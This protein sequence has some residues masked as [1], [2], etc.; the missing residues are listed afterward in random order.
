MKNDGVAVRITHIA[1]GRGDSSYC[2]MIAFPARPPLRNTGLS[3]MA[4]ILPVL[5]ACCCFA[6][7][8]LCW[9]SNDDDTLACG[10]R[11]IRRV[12]LPSLPLTTFFLRFSMIVLSSRLLL[13]L[14]KAS[15]ASK[16][17]RRGSTV[18]SSLRALS[19][20][21]AQNT[22]AVATSI[23]RTLVSSCIRHLLPFDRS[24]V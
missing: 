12:L 3:E 21:S 2:C 1:S 13:R 7:T 18:T 16:R 15:R 10:V 11:Q 14:S 20:L 4:M 6:L 5:L 23:S 19:S 22:Y 24:R 17:P 8:C 9:A